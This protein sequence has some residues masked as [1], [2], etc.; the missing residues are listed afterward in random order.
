[1]LSD[2][3]LS[4]FLQPE[5]AATESCLTSWYHSSSRSSMKCALAIAS[6]GLLDV[7]D[8][9]GLNFL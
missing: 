5:L 2:I 3:A 8:T 4:S 7:V 6:T 1:M 9:F